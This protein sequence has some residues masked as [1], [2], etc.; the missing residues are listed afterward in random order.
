MSKGIIGTRTWVNLK[1]REILHGVYVLRKGKKL[2]VTNEVGEPLFF[3]TQAEANH[4]IN[5]NLEKLKGLVP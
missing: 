2:N 3:D 4:Y 5:D 1:E